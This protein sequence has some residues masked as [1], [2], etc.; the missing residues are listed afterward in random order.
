MPEWEQMHRL[1]PARVE[2]IISLIWDRHIRDKETG[3]HNRHDSDGSG[4]FAFSGGS[5]KR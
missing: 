1:S 4:D 2:E 3:P 5:W